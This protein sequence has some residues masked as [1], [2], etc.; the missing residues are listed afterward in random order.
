MRRAQELKVVFMGTPEFAVV[1]LQKLLD[2]KIPV[3]GVV[4]GPDKP[5]GR[6]LQMQPTPVKKLALQAGLPILQPEKLR[7]AQFI[8]SLREWQ[9]EVFVVVA[10]RIL[11]PEVFTMPRLGTIN[12]HA[13][14]L[15]KY[16]GAAPIQWAIINGET[17]TGVTTFFIEEK[18]DTGEMILQRQT[19]IGEFETAGELHDRL[20]ALGAEV[21]VA[22]L[23]QV[24]SGKWQRKPQIGEASLAPKITKEMAAIDW[25]KSAREIFNL[26]RGMNPFPGAFTNW[27][28]RHLK[29][30][31]ARVYNEAAVDN[32]AGA[33]AKVNVKEGELII[34]TGR[35]HLAIDELQ[36]EGK[37]RMSAAEF[38]RGHPIRNHEK[39][40]LT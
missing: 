1:S 3:A 36:L 40:S 2:H 34:Q 31:R 7:D 30:F 4:T 6:G 14:L 20:A 16:R 26:V 25:K 18:V 19:A 9:A 10:F 39:L 8:Q 28:G 15:P 17:E 5:A 38:L 29:I 33:V 12:V 11:P 35:G 22:T 24:A 27:Q 13:S 21:L 32:D 37:R 23:E